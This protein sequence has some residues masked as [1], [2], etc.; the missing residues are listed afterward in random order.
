MMSNVWIILVVAAVAAG[1][2]SGCSA[3]DPGVASPQGPLAPEQ[4]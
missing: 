1:L 2:G 3:D 4:A